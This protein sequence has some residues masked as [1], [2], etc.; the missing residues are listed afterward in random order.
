MTAALIR[1][2]WKPLAGLLFAVALYWRGRRD[3]AQRADLEAAEAYRKTRERMDHEESKM[4]ADPATARKWLHD[5]GT[6]S[7]V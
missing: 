3:A 1:A 4:D 5:R 6:R 2:L 7:G